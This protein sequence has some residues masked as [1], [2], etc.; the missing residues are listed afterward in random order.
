M[1]STWI[2]FQQGR[3]VPLVG[4][5]C[6]HRSLHVAHGQIGRLEL[7]HA[8]QPRILELVDEKTMQLLLNDTG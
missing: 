3:W 8:G 7:M 6:Q 4:R 5:L 2:P 1:R